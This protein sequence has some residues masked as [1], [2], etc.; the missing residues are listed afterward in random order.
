MRRFSFVEIS[1]G[2]LVLTMGL[3]VI[4][5]VFHCC[6][7]C[8]FV[9]GFLVSKTHK[10]SQ[11]HRTHQQSH[12]QLLVESPP[13]CHGQSCPIRELLRG[14]HRPSANH[15]W[16]QRAIRSVSIQHLYS[17]HTKKIIKMGGGCDLVPFLKL[18]EKNEKV[19]NYLEL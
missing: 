19:A 12:D 1:I 11:Q 6:W 18:Q 15:S 2:Y 17:K 8:W 16:L 5:L 9:G 13:S 10:L 14:L 7:V 3:R 4:V